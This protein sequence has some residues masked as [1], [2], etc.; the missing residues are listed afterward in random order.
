M[1]SNEAPAN[2]VTNRAKFYQLALFPFNNGATNVYYI[3]TSSYIAYYGGVLGLLTVFAGTMV[4]VMRLFDAVTDPIIGALIDKTN[5]KFGKF[6]PFMVLG[7]II[8]AVA[9]IL[10]YFCTQF[11]PAS[12]MP[13]RYVLYVFFYAIYVIGYTFQTS[14]TRSGQT[15][16]TNDPSQRPMFTIFNLVASMLGMGAIQFCAPIIRANFGDYTTQNFFNVLIPAAIIVSACLTVLGVIGIWEKDQPKYFGMGGSTQEKV[17][18]SEYL[19]LIKANKPLQ[20]LMV[21]G[22]GCKLA[23][24]IA[25]NTAVLAMLYG[26]MMGN[27]DSLYLPLMVLGYV[28]SAPFF[29]LTIR[30]SQKKGQKAS[31]MRYVAVALICYVGVLV[32]LLMWKQGDP[33]WS[34]SL[35]S[36]SIG[37]S[38]FQITINLYTILFILFFGVGYGAY[39]A[40]AD[41]P[42]PMV[43]D[44]SDYET[45]RS[46]KYVPGI[47]GTLFS[48]VD[49]LV[50]SLS[51]TVVAL[52][53]AAIGFTNALPGAD[54]PFVPGMN[55]VVIVL[56]CAIPMVAWAATLIAMRGY[57]LTGAKMKEIQATNA[58]RSAA[59]AEG[60]TIEQAME[61][62]PCTQD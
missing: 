55:V 42:I 60:M 54:D 48:L 16:L 34:L 20:R 57:S 32:L 29:Y 25:T 10:L 33:V 37:Q 44:C 49:K 21:A 5:G 39:Y 31:L 46:G 13:L 43:A 17:K 11:V 36:G 24:A 15:V 14:V 8:M 38:D 53:A 47:I 45:Y 58:K 62:Y 35:F 12:M 30:T 40:T 59:V 52:A 27:Y 18:V 4:T 19:A 61:K 26:G 23:L 2:A 51:S 56:F 7:N 1:A 22:G 50:S 9:C 6:R 28:F 41:M 3:L